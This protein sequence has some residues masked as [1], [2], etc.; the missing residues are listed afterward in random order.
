VAFNGTSISAYGY[1][2]PDPTPRGYAYGAADIYVD[3]VLKIANQSWV[4][5]TEAP[6][7]VFEITGLAS[8]DHTLTIVANSSLNGPVKWITVDKFCTT[9]DCSAGH[10][11]DDDGVPY[12]FYVDADSGAKLS[13]NGVPIVADWTATIQ[14]IGQGGT[15]VTLTRNDNPIELSMFKQDGPGLMRLSW[16]S[17]FESKTVIPAKA[18]FP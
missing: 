7:K 6:G 9:S 13:V 16:S 10:V 8:G 18:L 15:T 5:A 17:P 4:A 12:T 11:M 1:M 2:G 14:A 3:G